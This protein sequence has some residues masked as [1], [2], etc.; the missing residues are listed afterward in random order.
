MTATQANVGGTT[1]YIWYSTN[2]GVTWTQS[3][4]VS[5]YYTS[6]C[7]SASGQYQTATMFYAPVTQTGTGFLYISTD[8]GQTWTQVSGL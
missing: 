7:C 6:V 3:N 4:S 2:Y 5:G 8:Y 1:S